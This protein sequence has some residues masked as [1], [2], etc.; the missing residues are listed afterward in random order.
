MMIWS[1]LA[2]YTAAQTEIFPWSQ[3]V[4]GLIGAAGGTGFAIWVAWYLISRKMPERETAFIVQMEAA[5]KRCAEKFETMEKRHA[6]HMA[7]E[8][9]SYREDMREAWKT[10]RE[11]N[12]RVIAVLEKLSTRMEGL[13]PHRHDEVKGS[14]NAT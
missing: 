7:L 8:K 4:S 2:D 10:N 11:N 14:H 3:G 12:D 5:E 13:V 1:L 9:I 6:D